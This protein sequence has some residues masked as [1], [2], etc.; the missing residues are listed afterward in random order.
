MLAAA[1]NA[2]AQA[3]IKNGD[4]TIGLLIVGPS[5]GV[6]DI[7]A[8]KR[9]ILPAIKSIAP[10][11][12]I[13][14]IFADLASN[15]WEKCMTQMAKLEGVSC[16][17]TVGL[18][19]E[20]IAVPESIHLAMSLSTLHWMQTLP[21]GDD[22]SK[23]DGAISYVTLKTK[24]KA[25]LRQHAN[26]HLAG[27]FAARQ[28]E[29]VPGGQVVVAFDGETPSTNH[30]FAL[31][32]D[33]LEKGLKQMIADN[34]LPTQLLSKYFI[35][36][37][38]F[39]KEHIDTMISKG[40]CGKVVEYAFLD[41][42]CPYKLAFDKDKNATA[43]GKEVGGAIIACVQKQLQSAFLQCNIGVSKH[44]RLIEDL[45]N[46]CEIIA[47]SNPAKYNT[48]GITAFV[49]LQKPQKRMPKVGL[50]TGCVIGA[51]IGVG[52]AMAMVRA[53]R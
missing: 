29:L 50:R 23:L 27:F 32:Y 18:A 44:K 22:Q 37:V 9:D 2:A 16:S 11:M 26:E 42:P 46:L 51:A 12:P 13:R 35:P 15:D 45:K 40:T 8:I 30:Q 25:M 47:A 3:A 49:H 52:L 53:R 33:L 19:N 14:A 5:T 1:G 43:C 34:M 41:I 31:T 48:S 7:A 6:K 24:P 4:T 10:N 38:S 21:W 20:V 39:G 17:A 36:T 28:I